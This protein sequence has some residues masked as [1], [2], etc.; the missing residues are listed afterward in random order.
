MNHSVKVNENLKKNKEE[1]NTREHWDNMKGINLWI[2]PK[3]KGEGGREGEDDK[4]KVELETEGIQNIFNKI[5]KES[6]W[7][8][9]KRG[10]SR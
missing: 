8:Y 2:L 9:E 3:G 6:F 5:I 7:N 10:F 1:Q 4:D